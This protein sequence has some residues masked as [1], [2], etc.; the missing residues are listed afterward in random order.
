MS[1]TPFGTEARELLGIELPI[2]LAPLAGG[3]STPE[4]AAAVSNAGALGSLG[5]GYATP[6]RI[7]DDIRALRRA[8]DR[9]FAVNLFAPEVVEVDVEAIGRAIEVLAPYREE[10]GLPP[11]SVPDRFAEDFDEQ[12][13]VVLEERIPVFTFTFGPLPDGSVEALHE[14]GTLVGG[15]V[16]TSSEA[17]ALAAQGVDF[18]V[19]Q[20]AEA[21]GHRGSFLG[22][23]DHGLIGLV[24]LVPLIRDTTR[25]PVVAAGG[26]GDG[27]GVAASLVLGA[28]AAQLG[29]A[30]LVCPEAGTSPPYRRAVLHSH[31]EDTVITKAFSG[32]RARGIANRLSADL[33]DREDLP[34]YPI[35]NRLTRGIRRVAA[36]RDEPELLSLWAGQGTGLIRVLP[37]AELTMRLAEEA[38]RAL[39]DPSWRARE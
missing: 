15:T 38:H 19:A 6:G 18:I 20:G 33:A 21:G 29:T 1:E 25:L 22:G 39:R 27:R 16:T 31:P 23:D 13:Q 10:L 17:E 26:I 32:R 34:P 35:L 30:Y 8:T 11:Q 3:P 4:L 24:S 12:F 14:V 36:A 7:R 2:V 28:V 5:Q 9:P 37:A